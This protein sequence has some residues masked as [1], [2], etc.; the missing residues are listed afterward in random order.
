MGMV[1]IKDMTHHIPLQ[2]NEIVEQTHVEYI[3]K[4]KNV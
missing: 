3:E 2:V 4:T 1:P